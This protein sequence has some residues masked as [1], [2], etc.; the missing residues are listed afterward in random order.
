MEKK[1][2]IYISRKFVQ[3][4]IVKPEFE[5]IY[6][7]GLELLLSFFT[8]T[9]IILLIGI[10]ANKI[11]HTCIF[12]LIFILLRRFTGGHHATSHLRCKL[13]T[14]GSYAAV[15]ILSVI[16][17]IYIWAY[18]LLVVLGSIIIFL[19]GP[20]ENVNKPLTELTKKKNKA[21]SLGLFT[22]LCLVGFLVY[23]YSCQLSNTVFYTLVD[24]IA[25]M[26]IPIL[27]KGEMTNA[28]NTRTN[29][30]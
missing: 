25:L 8:G 28:E 6:V 29:D 21:L 5:E 27:K 3:M 23:F 19:F 22:V 24:V 26:L 13:W 17:N 20:I 16:L 7:Y 10:V 14:I 15:L 30:R 18:L 12:L 11:A 1:L 2:A 4:E 9:V